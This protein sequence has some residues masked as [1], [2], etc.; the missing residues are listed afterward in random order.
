MDTI[1]LREWAELRGINHQTARRYVL[2]ERV[3]PM[4][5][6][7]RGAWAF[8]RD[9]VAVKLPTDRPRKAW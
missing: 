4:P 3:R 8:S 2:E 7:V 9:A 1:S 6:L 5:E